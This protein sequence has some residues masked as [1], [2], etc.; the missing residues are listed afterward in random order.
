MAS[1]SHLFPFSYCE[2]LMVTMVVIVLLY[3][4][5]IVLT[6]ESFL[7]L[8]KG[9]NKE[10]WT[11]GFNFWW[12]FPII[13][14]IILYIASKPTIANFWWKRLLYFGVS[15]WCE[16]CSESTCRIIFS[17]WLAMPLVTS[18]QCCTVRNQRATV[19]HLLTELVFVSCDECRSGFH[20]SYV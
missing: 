6:P 13:L 1:A 4:C 18:Y 8:C 16:Q 11:V 17:R 20:I 15:L 2:I 5:C 19:F 9:I 3:G 7:N 10:W 12:L 14:F